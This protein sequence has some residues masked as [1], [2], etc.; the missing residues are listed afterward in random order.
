MKLSNADAGSL[1]FAHL[2]GLAPRAEKGDDD[3]DYGRKSSKKASEDE[4]D[5][6]DKKEQDRSDG[7]S[8]KSRAAEDDK[9]DDRDEKDASEDDKGDD[10]DDK[11]SS[12]K[13]KRADD[14]DDD[15]EMRGNSPVARARR[16]EQ[17]R[18]AAIFADPKAA[19][20]PVLAASLAFETRLPRSEALAVLRSTPMAA[21]PFDHSAARSARNPSLGP[22][23][24]SGATDPSDRMV[25]RMRAARGLK[26]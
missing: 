20:N 22:S 11:K 9:D 23:G 19:H 3:K 5:E 10:E 2:A 13:A 7:D 6:D 14:E 17:A 21:S 8:K 18:C 25:A 12:K 15:T 16:R 4:D 26:S 1:S 24:G